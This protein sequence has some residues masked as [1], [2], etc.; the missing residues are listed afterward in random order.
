MWKPARL[1][2]RSASGCA[3]QLAAIAAKERGG[4]PRDD[5]PPFLTATRASD[6]AGCVRIVSGHMTPLLTSRN[7]EAC[8]SN[9]SAARLAS[10]N[11]NSGSRRQT[12]R[13]RSL[14]AVILIAAGCSFGCDTLGDRA[15]ACT[16]T[17]CPTVSIAIVWEK[18]PRSGARVPTRGPSPPDDWNHMY[19]RVRPA[20]TRGDDLPP[21][22]GTFRP[23]N[24]FQAGP[25]GRG[26][27]WLP[28]D[29]L[30]GL[31][32]LPPS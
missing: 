16:P 14:L 27:R 32:Q 5:V 31:S 3:R 6:P 30:S 7:I 9:Q 29:P 26:F 10:I 1:C 17:S 15:V 11:S 2:P 24:E 21:F 18:D 22:G 20:P 28:E 13:V 8:D 12:M 25:R 4:S 19:L 23:G